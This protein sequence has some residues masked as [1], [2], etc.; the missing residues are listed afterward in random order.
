MFGREETE[1][2]VQPGEQHPEGGLGEGGVKGEE[3][4]RRAVS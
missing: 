4:V 3:G 2:R 1:M